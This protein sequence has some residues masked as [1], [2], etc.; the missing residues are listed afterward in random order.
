MNEK[1]R[2]KALAQFLR[3]RREHISPSQ[4]GLPPGTRR[5]TPGL[6]REELASIAG[7]GTDWYTR[8]E[9]GRDITASAQIL[10]SLAHALKLDRDERAHLFVLARK[11][12]PV[13]PLPLTQSVDPTLQLILERMGTYPAAVVNHRWDMIAWNQATR[14]VYADFNTMSARERNVLWFLFT[15]PRQRTQ[16]LNWEEEARSKIAFFRASTQRYIGE[17]W[18]TELVNDLSASSPE[19]REWWPRH[20]VQRTHVKPIYFNHPLV[21]LLIFQIKIFHIVDDPDLQMIVST[22]VP[23]TETASKLTALSASGLREDST[24]C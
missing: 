18:F 10:E 3:T 2:R 17:T 6:R 16:W 22:P 21:G 20:D 24:F 4:V 7:V 12:L 5:R 14:Q 23:G 11:Q 13:D 9:Q 1:E 15:D 8:L 19:F